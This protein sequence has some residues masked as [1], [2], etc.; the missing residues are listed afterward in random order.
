MKSPVE[1]IRNSDI[2]NLIERDTCLTDKVMPWLIS[3]Q[4]KITPK[5]FLLKREQYRKSLKSESSSLLETSFS[6]SFLSLPYKSTHTV[7]SAN[8]T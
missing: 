5:L 1:T 6:K 7:N 2:M 8:S 4:Q 3:N